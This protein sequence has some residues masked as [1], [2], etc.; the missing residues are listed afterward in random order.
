MSSV[1][2]L[3][4]RV[5]LVTLVWLALWGDVSWGNVVGGLLVSAAVLSAVRLTMPGPTRRVSPAGTLRYLLAFGRDLVVATYQVVRQVFWPVGRL[6]PAVVEIQ[7]ASTDP[8]LLTL[9]ANT[10]TLTPGT[11]TLEVDPRRGVLWVHVLHLA[12]GEE[13]AVAEAAQQLERLGAAALRVDLGDSL[14]GAR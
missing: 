11:L 14:K 2:R 9:V 5:L 13:D 10:I 8:G 1:R 7:L 3:L 12:A 4:P 6:R